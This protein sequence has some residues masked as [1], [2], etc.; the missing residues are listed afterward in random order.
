VQQLL[1]AQNCGI[2]AARSGNAFTAV[3]RLNVLRQAVSW[4]IGGFQSNPT[5]QRSMSR[6]PCGGTGS[7][8]LSRRQRAFSAN[9]RRSSPQSFGTLLAFYKARAGYARCERSGYFRRRHGG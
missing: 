5:V 4:A 7:V 6:F 2:G 9:R 8:L 3:I 1:L